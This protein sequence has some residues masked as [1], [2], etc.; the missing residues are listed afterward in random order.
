MRRLLAVMENSSLSSDVNNDVTTSPSMS[1]DL[2][3]FVFKVIYSIIGIVGVV[4]NLFV[5]MV[6]ILFIKITDKVCF[7]T[8]RALCI[9]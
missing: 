6:F 3:S 4:D 9:F 5:L 1:D 2:M 7:R 8:S